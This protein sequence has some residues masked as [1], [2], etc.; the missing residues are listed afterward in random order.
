[1]PNSKPLNALIIADGDKPC[2]DKLKSLAKSKQV[3]VLDGAYEF[4]LQSGVEIDYLLGD[5]DTITKAQLDHAKQSG[6]EV[7]Q[8]PDQN[9]TDLDKAIYF[10]DENNVASIDIVAA[11]GQRLDHTLHNIQLL[12]RCYRADRPLKIHT[13]IETLF[14]IKDEVIELKGKA[15][16][17]IALLGAPHAV[18]STSGLKYDMRDFEMQYGE[19][20][21]TC[22][23]FEKA[24]VRIQTSGCSLIILENA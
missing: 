5:F 12:T 19:Q 4:A 13:P 1:M 21:S 16:Q 3:I 24:T 23:H 2:H 17:P 7:I 20:N 8:T 10:C 11:T 15:G 18:V 6:I 22:N 14:V 9:H